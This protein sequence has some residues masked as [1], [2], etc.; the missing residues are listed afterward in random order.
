MSTIKIRF[1]FVIDQGFLVTA[2]GGCSLMV[3]QVRA[4]VEIAGGINRAQAGVPV[5]LRLVIDLEH[6]PPPLPQATL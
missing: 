4:R 3:A 6:L 2:E 1:K 5:L